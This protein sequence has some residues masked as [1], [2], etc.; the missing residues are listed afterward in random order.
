GEHFAD[1]AGG[2]AGVDQ[3]VDDQYFAAILRHVEDRLADGLEHLDAA[4]VLVVIALDGHG[5]DRADIELARHD[6]RRNEAAAGDGD[7]GVERAHAGQPPGQRPAV[8]VELVPGHG[9]RL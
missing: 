2:G 8:A 3:I 7:D 5:L 4:L 6:G 1:D 9:E